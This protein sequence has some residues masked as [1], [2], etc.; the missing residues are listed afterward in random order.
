MLTI[1]HQEI[2]IVR[3]RTNSNSTFCD[4]CQLKK[5]TYSPEQVAAIFQISI[6]DVCR[7]I[8]NGRFHLTN[9]H[10]GIAF[11]CSESLKSSL[12]IE[13]GRR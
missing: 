2:E 10:C 5:G 1:E 4:K 9:R 7:N 3:I 13:I 11:V 8:A 12:T 6:Y